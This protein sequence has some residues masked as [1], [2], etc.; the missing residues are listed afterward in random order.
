MRRAALSGDEHVPA[1]LSQTGLVG[2][3]HLS[4]VDYPP[5]QQAVLAVL[6]RRQLTY[7]LRA[8]AASR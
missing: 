7:R 2:A 5:Q 3:C 1:V 8:T 6:G 4:R